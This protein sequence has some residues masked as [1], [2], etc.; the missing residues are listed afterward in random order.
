MSSLAT[1]ADVDMNRPAVIVS[2]DSHVG[3]KLVEHL[4]PYCPSRYL[5]AFDADVARQARAASEAHTL[6]AR[7]DAQMRRMGPMY[8]HPNIERDGHWD[9]V[10]RLS[11]MDGDGV[12]AELIWHFSQNG[13][14]LPWVGIGLGNVYADQLELGAVA[15]DIYNR[16]L[17]DFCSTDPQRLRGLVYIPSWDIDASIRTL[18]WASDHGLH[19]VNFPA[20][21]RPCVKEYNHW[22]WDPFW[23]ACTDLGFTLST[24][25]SGGPHFDFFGGPG[26]MQIVAY[27]GGSFMS[28]RAVWILTYGEVFKRHPDLKLVI[29]EQVEGWFAPTMHELDSF[30]MSFGMDSDLDRLPSEYVRS[31]VYLGA[32]FISPWQAED[33]IAQGYVDNVLWGRDYPHIE[34][35][36]QATVGPDEEP[37]TKLALR[38]V[39][40]RIP[41]IDALKILGGNAV[42]VL[43]LDGDHLQA[44][45]DRIGASTPQQLSVAPESLPDNDGN[46]FMGQAGPRPLEPERIA[47][48]EQRRAMMSGT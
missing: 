47:R 25:S 46:G 1:A 3:P 33:A 43:G 36:F 10:A 37:M 20:P 23:S 9:P 28:R 11:D 29:T 22:D 39:L 12:A 4:R 8:S 13:E 31:N 7:M 21:G 35:V 15:Y 32:S 41:P 27:E 19:G 44:V 42:R 14:N 16:W 5:D 40:H 26:G 34:G 17:A 24:H 45:A 18:R 6:N 48:G 38:H 2:C 30:Y